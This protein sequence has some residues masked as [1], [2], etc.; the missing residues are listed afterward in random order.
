MWIGA[1][2]AVVL[3]AMNWLLTPLGGDIQV[4]MASARLADADGR[5][6]ANVYRTFHLRG[7]GYKVIM[8]GIYKAASALTSLED[9]KSF[10]IAVRFIYG[11]LVLASVGLAV[12]RFRRR[13]S[14]AGFSAPLLFLLCSA[15]LFSMGWLP[16][17][18]PEEISLW[19]IV[20]GVT[21]ALGGTRAN[22]A[23]G[24]VL[25]A[26]V[27][28]KGVTVLF[29]L[30]PLLLLFGLGPKYQRRMLV[31]GAA[32]A[33]S[34]IAL[35]AIMWLWMPESREELHIASLMR[36]PSGIT[37][38]AQMVSNMQKLAGSYW[39]AFRGAP[40]LIGSAAAAWIMVPLL[41][42]RARW[43]QLVALAGIWGVSVAAVISQAGY[44]AQQ[45]FATAA[46]M[47]SLLL[48]V[49]VRTLQP[50]RV[51]NR[52]APAL[53]AW[54]CAALIVVANAGAGATYA[55]ILLLAISG[56]GVL[57]GYFVL[58]G[59]L[60]RTKIVLAGIFGALSF[61]V[62]G[63]VL[64]QS[65]LRVELGPEDALLL[66]LT[67]L[68]ALWLQGRPNIFA[69]NRNLAVV[70]VVLLGIF[71]TVPM[72][73]TPGID[74]SDQEHEYIAHVLEVRQSWKALDDRFGL[75]G[76]AS[77]LFLDAG[78]AAYYLDAGSACKHFFP[79]PLQ[80]ADTHP[81]LIA[82]ESYRNNLNCILAYDG[83]YVIV[84]EQW[85]NPL[86]IPEANEKLSREYEMVP[87]LAGIAP[88][89]ISILRR[90]PASRL[91]G[92]EL[93]DQ[94]DDAPAPLAFGKGH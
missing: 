89:G 53:L 31:S 63:V 30:L 86:A 69:V 18:E 87:D 90:R 4:S 5:F 20:V 33:C 34:A 56:T 64:A 46:I 44:G 71:L 27:T 77:I 51:D 37:S 22:L 45:L 66:G 17:M 68:A 19:F 35:F 67:I 8:Y 13:L 12:W 7:I 1:G 14:D 3:L 74:R 32:F 73:Q 42:W 79:L 70:S 62:A 82:T 60:D 50:G 59:G 38:P 43:R 88:D 91:Q 11:L 65:N 76:Q 28:L 26:L 93:Q 83:Q 52:L 41:L 80:R 54:W 55:S 58:S 21:L 10:E 85:F 61:G 48:W 29:G 49:E 40:V 16:S 25:G 81:L 36:D 78:E 39:A 57:G 24:A 84:A 72:Y 2:L 15:T 75:S 92:Y 94:E 9:K 23:A 47:S 6:P